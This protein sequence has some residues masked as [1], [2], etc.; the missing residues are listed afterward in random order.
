MTDPDNPTFTRTRKTIEVA[1][2]SLGIQSLPLEVRRPQDIRPAFAVAGNQLIDAIGA[3]TETVT[4]A[5]RKL[6]AELA[7]E[8]RLPAI[9]GSRE[10]VDVGGLISY[11]V[12]YP[13]L[14]RRAAVYVDKILK[15]AKPAD[16]PIEQPTRFNTIVNLRAA[17][18]IGLSMPLQV[19]A[20]ADEVIE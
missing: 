4:Q 20:T 6:I 10:F 17:K 15:G 7:I 12:N 13:D 1:A 9:Y 2:H 3:G 5:S 11:G 8:Y 18:A 16:L 19:L 14:Y